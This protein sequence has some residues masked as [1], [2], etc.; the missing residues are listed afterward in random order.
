MTATER[1]TTASRDRPPANLLANRAFILLWLA[2]GVSAIGDDLSHK[3]ILKTV[4]AIEGDQLTRFEAL[5]TFMFMAPFFVLSPFAGMLADRMSR[6][7]LMVFADLARAGLLLVFPLLLAALQP[8]GEIGAFLPLTFLGLFA[9]LFSP[10][11]L[12]LLPTL[13]REDQLMRANALTSGLGVI[14]TVLAFLIGG[15]LAAR[16]EPRVAFWIDAATFV[17]SAGLLMMLRPPG[18]SGS[19]HSSPAGQQ[20]LREGIRYVLDHRRIAQLIAI[21]VIVWACGAAVMSTI[22]ALVRDVYVPHLTGDVV[23]ASIGRFQALLGIGVLTG[24]ILLA[25]VGDALRAG[26]AITGSLI[27]IGTAMIVLGLTAVVPMPSLLARIIGGVVIFIA[28]MFTSGVMAGYHALLQRIVPNRLRGRVFGLTDQA[29]RAG[30]LL[31]T[32]SLG[33]PAW[34]QPDRW[35]GWILLAVAVVVLTTGILSLVWHLRRSTL[36]WRVAFWWKINELYCRFWFRLERDG[37]CTVPAEGPV[38]VV[39][40]H[41]CAIDPLLLIASTPH[42]VIAFLIAEEFADV[43]VGGRLTRMIGCIPVKRDGQDSGATRAAL[44]HLKAG[45]AL[46]I[47]IEGRI[48]QPGQML[49]PKDGAAM[50]ALHSNAIVVPAYISGTRYDPSVPKTFFKRHHARVRYG[51]PI[52]PSRYYTPRADRENVRRMSDR[53]IQHIRALGEAEKQGSGFGAREEDGATER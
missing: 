44:R 24:A 29:T 22:P 42:R 43:P 3:A 25:V 20:T 41:T 52:D 40:N 48:A 34:A 27:G 17:A 1:Q 36:E 30:L 10:A 46:G 15:E 9:T 45:N 37:I 12:A 6:R 39:A 26:V 8:F 13:I 49:D 47:F 7:G 4:G 23:F 18:Q 21:A 5:I 16:Y 32:G 51:Q 11:R 19:P 14:A 2:V 38:I 33:I 31:A 53:F 35:I 28:G 50:L